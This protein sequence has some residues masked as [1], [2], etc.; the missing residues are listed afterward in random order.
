[1]SLNQMI[2]GWKNHLLPEERKRAFIE[3]VS[4]TRLATCNE[5]E[6]HS[7]NKKEYKSLRLDAHCTNCGCTL[8]AKTKCLTCEC[9]LKKWLPQPMP[10]DNGSTT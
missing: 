9:P 5:C 2:E 1:M 4:S 3:H 7:S 6:E 8:A 10:E